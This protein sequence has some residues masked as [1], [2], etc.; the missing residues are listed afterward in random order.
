MAKP[1]D[2]LE[3]PSLGLRIEFG[4]TTAETGGELLEFDVV[5][6][7]R[8]FI[9]QA[10]VHP[11]QSER[12][13]VIEGAMS[14]RLGGRTRILRPG[15]VIETP[16][17]AAH[18]H[19]AAGDGP[20]SVR[21]QLRPARRT[22]EWLE[23]LAAM[24]AA[25]QIPRGGYPAPVAGA[26]LMLDFAGEAHASGLP[27]RAQQ[28]LARAVLAVGDNRYEFV[29]EWDVAAPPE[30]VFAALE[31]ARSYPQWWRPVYL[32]A[33]ADG[34]TRVGHSSTQRFKGRLPYRLSTRTT[35][36]RHEPPRLLEGDVEGDLRGRGTWTLTPRPDGGTHVHFDWRVLADRPLLRALTPVLRPALRWNHAWAIARARD[37][38]EPFAQRLST[39]A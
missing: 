24:D 12:H 3:V 10:H 17:G 13:E 26:R 6:R 16:P 37:G 29:D 22:E 25:G 9:A 5:G 2:V 7:P 15:D 34:P 11:H 38:L 18:R 4:R 8:G 33:Q 19:L 14:M 31:D 23:R 1:G 30:A 35:T 21:V 28:A 20:G 39:A 36:V 32:Q 27:P